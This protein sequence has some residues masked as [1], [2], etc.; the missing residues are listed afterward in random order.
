MP[1]ADDPVRQEPPLDTAALFDALPESY[2]VLD[3]KFEVVAA[4]ARY[5]AISGRTREEV[6]G[7]SVFHINPSLSEAQMVARREWL[8]STLDNLPVGASRLSPPIRYDGHPTGT[9]NARRYWQAKVTHLSGSAAAAYV[10]Q[11]MDVT[12]QTLQAEEAQREHARLRSQAQLRQVLVDEANAALQTHREQLEELLSFAKVGA[13]ELDVATGYMACTNQCKANMGLRPEDQIDE[14]RVFDELMHADD[15]VAVRAAIDLAIATQTHFEVEYRVIWRDGT[16]RW[17]MSRGAA[18][19]LED[20][21]AQSLIGFTID[22]TARKASELHYQAVAEEEQRARE[23][24]ERGARA[25]DHFVAA[26]SHELRSPLHAILWW[27]TLLERS[28]DPSHVHRAAE[29][30]E[31]NTRQLAR[32]VDDLLDSGAIA[33]GKLSVDLQPLDMAALAATVAEDLRLDAESRAVTLTVAPA[34][35]CPVM[36]DEHR[37]KQIVLNLL[38]NALK[39][40]ERGTVDLAVAANGGYVVLSVRDSGVGISAEALERIFERFEQAHREHA[41]R[42]PGLGLGLWMVKNLVLM[43]HGSVSAHSDGL[44]KG[45]TFRVQLPLAQLAAQGIQRA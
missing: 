10:L 39:F 26:V 4:N 37:L 35:P 12:D 19:Y 41:H 24:S 5:L 31:R 28:A 36:A 17:L 11:V 8:A 32:M 21:S 16:M 22:I 15:R 2:L 6:I 7:K 42:A 29:V 1:D 33:T 13:W 43:H 14:A 45:S 3:A 9:G 40:A 30:I 18:R 44:G 23:I 38:S 27:T 34:L 20:Q 25:M